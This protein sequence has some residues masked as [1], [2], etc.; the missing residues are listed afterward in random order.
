M[1]IVKNQGETIGQCG[2]LREA[3][4]GVASPGAAQVPGVGVVVVSGAQHGGPARVRHEAVGQQQPAPQRRHQRRLQ[5]L[6]LA[7]L[8]VVRLALLHHLLAEARVLGEALF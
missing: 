6:P 2:S 7:P 5:R 1:S 4:A 3:G 8:G